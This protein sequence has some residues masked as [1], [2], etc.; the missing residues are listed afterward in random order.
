MIMT[1]RDPDSL[2]VLAAGLIAER[3]D[4]PAM[5]GGSAQFRSLCL[6]NAPFLSRRIA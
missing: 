3:N 5:I 2:A 4:T 1:E 6:A